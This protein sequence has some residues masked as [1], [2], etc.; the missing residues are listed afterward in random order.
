VPLKSTGHHNIRTGP[1]EVEEPMAM[2]ESVRA[3][4]MAKVQRKSGQIFFFF[5]FFFNSVLLQNQQQKNVA[6]ENADRVFFMTL[7]EPAQQLS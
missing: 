5:S 7:N 1:E 2:S 3:T 6:E 4:V